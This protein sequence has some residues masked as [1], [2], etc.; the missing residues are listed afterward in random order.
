MLM[1]YFPVNP[2]LSTTVRPSKR[3][4]FC[5]NSLTCI[6][7]ALRA[8]GPIRNPPQGRMGAYPGSGG[9]GEFFGLN[10]VQLPAFDSTNLGPSLLSFLATTSA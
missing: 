7:A 9:D 8:V 10:A 3:E 6:L 1:S 2:V 5:V 4:K